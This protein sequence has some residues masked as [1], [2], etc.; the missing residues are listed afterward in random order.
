MYA[1]EACLLQRSARRS[2]ATAALA[3]EDDGLVLELLEFSPAIVDD[4][5]FAVFV[6][7]GRV[8]VRLP[9]AGRW[10]LRGTDL[11]PSSER[12]GTWDSRFITLA[13][14][15]AAPPPSMEVEE[16]ENPE[17][18]A[19]GA[20]LSAL[21]KPSVGAK[22]GATKPGA[23]TGTKRAKADKP[24]KAEPAAKRA[25]KVDNGPPRV[26]PLEPSSASQVAYKIATSEGLT[27]AECF[28]RGMK[29]PTIE[30]ALTG[31]GSA[32]NGLKRSP[33]APKDGEK[34]SKKS[35]DRIPD[36]QK[37][38]DSNV[39]GDVPELVTFESVLPKVY[40]K[41][42]VSL[43]DGHDMTVGQPVTPESQAERVENRLRKVMPFILAVPGSPVV[44]GTPWLRG[45]DQESKNTPQ[46]TRETR[47]PIF[48][49]T[50]KRRAD[51]FGSRKWPFD[52]KTDAKNPP[53]IVLAC[54]LVMAMVEEAGAELC[55]DST[56]ERR[57]E[58]LVKV[59]SHVSAWMKEAPAKL[60]IPSDSLFSVDALWK[61]ALE[62]FADN[63]RKRWP[64]RPK[65]VVPNMFRD[66]FRTEGERLRHEM[67]CRLFA[68]KDGAVAAS[69]IMVADGPSSDTGSYGRRWLSDASTYFTYNDFV[70]RPETSLQPV[71]E[72]W[73]KQNRNNLGRMRPGTMPDSPTP[74]QEDCSDV[75]SDSS[76]DTATLANRLD[77]KRYKARMFRKQMLSELAFRV[78]S[79][80]SQDA[81]PSVH[82][83]VYS[84]SDHED[85]EGAFAAETP[86]PAPSP[87]TQITYPLMPPPAMPP[88]S[89]SSRESRHNEAMRSGY[90][91]LNV[92]VIFSP[93]STQE[94]R[95]QL[96][97]NIG[98]ARLCVEFTTAIGRGSLP[99][100]DSLAKG[101]ESCRA[102]FTLDTSNVAVVSLRGIDPSTVS[103]HK[104]S[105]YSICEAAGDVVCYADDPR[106]PEAEI[107]Q[108]Y[109]ST[110]K[111][112]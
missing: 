63:C 108:V 78:P 83:T 2:G 96:A 43:L 106:D 77:Q 84:D 34:K 99:W 16:G 86:D 19:T 22:E 14:E 62:I 12:P 85:Q 17:A 28:A 6:A 38:F 66:G 92:G 15:V 21:L 59:M 33:V 26:T 51:L 103:I 32:V 94:Q 76:A 11:R 40:P 80:P 5:Q 44:T 91:S 18:A 81:A 49:R 48:E 75:D 104:K 4:R 56:V 60:M 72:T 101:V 110:T 97:A 69:E 64:L 65:T 70:P 98:T 73:V 95:E 39:T 25:K 93:A 8:Q 100:F 109:F 53:R 54:M 27:A 29:Y 79:T 52:E 31:H 37:V 47:I 87:T 30:E 24:E 71:Y 112:A 90:V 105:I 74:S 111:Y 58:R 9:L 102:K 10:V 89:S 42:W 46:F 55:R 67:F 36:I 82:G 61:F 35:E 88:A 23:K 45:R 57:R 7:Q 13:F 20:S 50:N 41:T 3:I 68:E 107:M 1:G